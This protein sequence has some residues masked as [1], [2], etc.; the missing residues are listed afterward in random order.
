[1]NTTTKR[2]PRTLHEAFPNDALSACAIEHYKRPS[3]EFGYF[4]V[5]I[6]CVLGLLAVVSLLVVGT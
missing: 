2:Y 6:I 3:S 4:A 1:M 5:V